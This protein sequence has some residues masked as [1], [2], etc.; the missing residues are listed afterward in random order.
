MR[1]D[2]WK[3]SVKTDGLLSGEIVPREG[4]SSLDTMK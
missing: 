3:S 4:E 1:R 2:E